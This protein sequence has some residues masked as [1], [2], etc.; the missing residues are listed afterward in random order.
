MLLIPV[1]F[2]PGI[3]SSEIKDLFLVTVGKEMY[4]PT[5]TGFKKCIDRKVPDGFTV[6][7]IPEELKYK[8]GRVMYTEIVNLIISPD[9]YTDGKVC[10]SRKDV[11]DKLITYFVRQENT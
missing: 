8:K 1:T 2:K 9:T 10:E 5:K 11:C 6:V 4:Y 3:F 7:S